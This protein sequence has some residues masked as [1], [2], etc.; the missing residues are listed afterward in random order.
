MKLET[1]IKFIDYIL[2]DTKFIKSEAVILDF[3]GGEPLLEAS[4]IDQICDYFKT[5]TYLNI[6]L[7]L[8]TIMS[9]Y[10]FLNLSISYLKKVLF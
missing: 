8:C 3:I 10:F 7:F 1:A 9:T 4:L 6:M 2:E 5:K